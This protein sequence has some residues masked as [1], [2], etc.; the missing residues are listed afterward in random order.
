M[1]TLERY[2]QSLVDFGIYELRADQR[3]GTRGPQSIISDENLR[4]DLG[5][6]LRWCAAELI[7][8]RKNAG[9]RLCQKGLIR[10]IGFDVNQ[11][12]DFG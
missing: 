1:K 6:Q 7:Q 12:L 8:Q 11:L 10:Q 5:P 4:P 2:R 3:L 9:A